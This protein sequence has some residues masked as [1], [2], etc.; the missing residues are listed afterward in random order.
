MAFRQCVLGKSWLWLFWLG[1]A[2]FAFCFVFLLDGEAHIWLGDLRFRPLRF[3]L[4]SL[5]FDLPT[6]MT[7]GVHVDVILTCFFSCKDR[8]SERYRPR[9]KK[10]AMR[11]FR[12]HSFEER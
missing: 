5:C 11:H 4:L 3:G 1:P 9:G 6:Y 8:A 10:K 2:P 7:T 12:C